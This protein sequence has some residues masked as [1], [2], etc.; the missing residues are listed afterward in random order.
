MLNFRKLAADLLS[1]L[2]R[3]IKNRGAMALEK[4]PL[5]GAGFRYNGKEEYEA[6][7]FWLLQLL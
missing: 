2:P 6:E 3:A 5:S 7:R 1:Y 4:G